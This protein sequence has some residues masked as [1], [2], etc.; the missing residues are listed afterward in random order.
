MIFPDLKITIFLLTLWK[1]I[2]VAYRFTRTQVKL[3]KYVAD[4]VKVGILKYSMNECHTLYQLKCWPDGQTV[5]YMV[6][7]KWYGL[8]GKKKEISNQL[9]LSYWTTNYKA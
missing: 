7:F 8:K 3:V 1:Y 2:L 9:A 6:D 4:K 5:S